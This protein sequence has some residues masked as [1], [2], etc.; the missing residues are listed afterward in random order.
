MA[1]KLFSNRVTLKLVKSFLSRINCKITTEK[2]R[3]MFNEVDVMSKGDLD[4]DDFF[5]LY[6]KLLFDQPVNNIIIN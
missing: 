2:L 6:Q 4:F 5:M 3:E 1:I